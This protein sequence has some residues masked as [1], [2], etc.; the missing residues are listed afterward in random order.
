MRNNIPKDYNVTDLWDCLEPDKVKVGH[1]LEQAVESNEQ[2][3]LRES[4]VPIRTLKIEASGDLWKGLIKPK[5]RLM[6]YWLERAGF[7]PGTHV[8]VKCIAPGILELH[9]SDKPRKRP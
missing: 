4:Q 5:I 3:K 6:G 8:H 7:K 9:S 1:T 2:S